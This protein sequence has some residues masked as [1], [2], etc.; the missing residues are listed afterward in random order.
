MDND[1]ELSDNVKQKL[2]AA[3]RGGALFKFYVEEMINGKSLLDTLVFSWLNYTH[4]HPAKYGS[5]LDRYNEKQKIYVVSFDN[6]KDT[7]GLQ[8]WIMADAF[9]KTLLKIFQDDN[10]RK[11]AKTGLLTDKRCKAYD[12]TKH[13]TIKDIDATIAGKGGKNKGDAEEGDND[14][15]DEE[16]GDDD[17]GDEEEE[18]EEGVN[19]EDREQKKRKRKT[20]RKANFVAVEQSPSPNTEQQNTDRDQRQREQLVGN[21]NTDRD[22]RQ[23]ARDAKKLKKRCSSWRE[24]KTTVNDNE[25]DDLPVSERHCLFD[26]SGNAEGKEGEEVHGVD[27]EEEGN[28]YTQKKRKVRIFSHSTDNDNDNEGRKKKREKIGRRKAKKKIFLQQVTENSGETETEIESGW[29]QS[30]DNE[31]VSSNESGAGGL[32]STRNRKHIK[33]NQ[34]VDLLLC[35]L[36]YQKKKIP[37]T[38]IQRIIQNLEP[39]VLLFICSRDQNELIMNSIT[40]RYNTS[41]HIPLSSHITS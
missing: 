23:K 36:T 37:H 34:K 3:V 41:F 9:Q 10:L 25:N 17:D 6:W 19:G 4:A 38:K 12:G 27:T 30:S 11:L 20:T 7:V 16:E 8:D 15:G 13:K 28:T 14:D 29:G 31:I 24:R 26:N 5:Q 33:C 39:K 22:Q 32:M 21:K 35:N 18:E 40:P 1:Y 2:D